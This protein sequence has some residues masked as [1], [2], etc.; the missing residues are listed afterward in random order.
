MVHQRLERERPDQATT[1]NKKESAEAVKPIIPVHPDLG[2]T[3]N[4][5]PEFPIDRDYPTRTYAH[6]EIKRYF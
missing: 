3:W 2:V 1:K 4:E 5:G 6:F